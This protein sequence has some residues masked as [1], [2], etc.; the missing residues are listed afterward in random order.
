M[1]FKYEVNSSVFPQLKKYSFNREFEDLNSSLEI[2][3][4]CLNL[5]DKV[6]ETLTDSTM[7]VAVICSWSGGAQHFL[8]LTKKEG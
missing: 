4:T 1:H 8:C 7:T 2:Q 3:Y 6:F 5:V